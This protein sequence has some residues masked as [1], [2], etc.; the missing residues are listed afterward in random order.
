MSAKAKQSPEIE[1]NML[2][3]WFDKK[4]GFLKPHYNLIGLVTI[5]VLLACVLG[6][7]LYNVS[8]ENYA[9]QW[10]QLN[11][12]L[13]NYLNDQKTDHLTDMAADLPGTEASLW[14][15]QIAGDQELNSGMSK[16]TNPANFPGED[17]D[18][19]RS[20]ALRHINNAKK[21]YTQIL[22]SQIH[23]PEMLEIRTVFSLARAC[24]SLGEWDNAIKY[25]SQLVES[26]PE[27][28][29]ADFAKRGI[30]RVSNPDFVKFYE[31][32]RSSKVGEAPGITL[33]ED[34]EP[35]IDFPEI[36]SDEGQGS[37][38]PEIADPGNENNEAQED[39]SDNNSN[40]NSVIEDG[41]PKIEENKSEDE[42]NSS[43]DGDDD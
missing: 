8:R 31:D 39:G 14:A 42:N 37:E 21:N 18:N 2:V 1:E 11:L 28:D 7:V 19:L 25:Y 24:E 22:E 13:T 36:G 40:E 38:E 29:F 33:P 4:F 23:R 3:S 5:L 10:N 6:A 30:A 17:S 15:L 34:Q 35:N 26:Y 12:S 16:M 20:T 27:S 9:S 32:F 41:D 43:D